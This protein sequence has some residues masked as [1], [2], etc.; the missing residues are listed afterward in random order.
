MT[1]MYQDIDRV[2]PCPQSLRYL[3]AVRAVSDDILKK[4]H[5]NAPLHSD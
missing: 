1:I 4:R 2:V 5:G 3:L